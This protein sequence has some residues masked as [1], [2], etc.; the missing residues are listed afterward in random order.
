M[1]KHVLSIYLEQNDAWKQATFTNFGG[2]FLI[3]QQL[4]CDFWVYWQLFLNLL[5]QSIYA[6][7]RE[8][9]GRDVTEINLGVKDRAHGKKK[10]PSN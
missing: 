7:H 9:N 8:E 5:V 4:Q 2:N 3:V 1:Y 6:Y 10:R